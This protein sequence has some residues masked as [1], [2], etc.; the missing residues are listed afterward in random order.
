MKKDI[1]DLTPKE[2]E[3]WMTAMGEPPHRARQIFLWLNRKNVRSFGMMTDLPKR[4]V[5]ELEKKF[6]IGTLECVEHLISKDGT[7]KFLWELSDKNHVETV[8]IQEGN[9]R[10]LCLSTQVGCKFACP[11][12]ASGVRGF[13]RDLR[14][15]EIVDQLFCVQQFCPRRVT[16][17]VFM[18]M[19]E[20]LDNYD[21]LEKA[22]RMINHPDG[23]GIAAR[24]ITVSTCGIIPGIMKL[25]DIGLQVELSVSLHAADDRLRNEL[26][27]ASRRY[28]LEKLVRACRE[29]Y[30]TTGRVVT[31]EYTLIKGRN[32]TLKSA[33]E[34]A[35]IAKKIKA[36]VNL[37]ECNPFAELGCGAPG[38]K[39]MN[40]FAAR[41]RS[42]GVTATTRRSR[43]EDILAACGQLAAKRI[44]DTG[45][46]K[47]IRD[48]ADEV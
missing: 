11:F 22:I 15:S 10:T 24:K 47:E 23:A 44:S 29:Y 16:N 31:L 37:I 32:D 13:T 5:P 40:A 9:R 18:G 12:C 33:G 28:P 20:P 4:L 36:K 46:G 43:G 6:I 25:K 27:P 3:K 7:E 2:L 45:N 35:K 34:L 21:N 26:V 8:L 38:K 39:K 17:I 19:G 14:V 41:V 42:R 48:K 1:R 30:E